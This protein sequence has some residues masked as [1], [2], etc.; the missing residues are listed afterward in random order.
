VLEEAEPG[1]FKRCHIPVAE[2]REMQLVR[3]A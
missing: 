2:L 3:L 1:Y